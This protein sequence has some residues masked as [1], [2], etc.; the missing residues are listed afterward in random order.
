[1]KKYTCQRCNRKR[2]E[3]HFYNTMD[4]EG[5]KPDTRECFTCIKRL[6]YKAEYNAA[7]YQE[8]KERISEYQQE[9]KDRL[10]EYQRKYYQE[11][12]KKHPMT[13]EQKAERREYAK[14]YREENPEKAKEAKRKSQEKQKKKAKD[15]QAALWLA[16]LKIAILKG[17]WDKNDPAILRELEK[18]G[19]TIKD[20]E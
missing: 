19:K 15:I 7:Y 16:N 4:E 18:M 13:E 11:Y 3:A 6:E 9:H 10:N 8:N 20:L 17:L 1:M 12:R 2:E 14:K 5:I